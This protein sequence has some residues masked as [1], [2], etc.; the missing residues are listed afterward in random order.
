MKLYNERSGVVIRPRKGEPVQ[1]SEDIQRLLNLVSGS[2][3]LN[4]QE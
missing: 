4:N 3:G 1:E 2:E